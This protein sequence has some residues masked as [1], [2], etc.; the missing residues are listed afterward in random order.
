MAAF[1]VGLL[2][3]VA[4]TTA[5]LE[6][7]GF[8]DCE[9]GPLRNNSVC[10][11]SADPLSRAT[12]LIAAFTLE[13]KLNN[14]GSTAPGVP[15]LGLPAY[16]WWQEALHGV[17][18]SPGVNFS[19]SGEFRYAT[20][21]PQPIL[22]GAAF[23]DELIKDVATV[24]ST[25]A[26][27]F[28]NANRAG[29]D[30]WTPN[31]NPFKD[32]RWGR[33]QETPGEDPLHL[34]SYV[35]S[36]IE[37]LQGSPDDKYKRVVATCKHFVAYDI[38][39]W[40]GNFRYQFDAQVNQ[41]DLVEYYMPPF[42][43]CAGDSNVGAFMCSYNALNG[44]P[45]CA[46]PWLLQTVLREHW[47][48]TAEEQ[49]VTSDCDAIQ[50]VY[51]PHEYGKTREEA[52]ALSLKAGT[53]VNCGTYYQE[54][55][56]AAYDQGLIN[57]TD[58]NTA[59]IRQYSSLVRLGYFDGMA[60]PYRSLTWDD[61]STPQAQQLAYKAAVEGITLLKNDGT[62][63]FQ[64]QNSTKIALIGD[65]ANATDQMLGNYDGIPPYF[66]SPLYAA[67]QSGATVNFA[68]YPGGQGDP[69]TDNWL[70]IWNAANNSDVIVYAGGIDNSVEAEAQLDV[71]GQL[72][73]YGK[74]VIVLQMG[75]GQ[76]DSSPLVNNPNISALIWGGYPGQDGGVALF[77]IIQGKA[78][79]AGRLPTTQYPADYISQIPMTDMTLRPNATTGSPGRTYMWYTGKPIYEFGYG[80]HY[81]NFSASFSNN[82][83]SAS[84]YS[85]SSLLDGCTESYKDRCAFQTFAVDVKNTGAVTSDYVTLGFLAGT[86]GPAPYPRK[87][88]VAYQRLHNVTGGAMQTASLNLTLNSL[89]RVDDMGNKV[90]YPGDYALLIDTQP[91][92]TVNFTL[93]GEPA[94]LDEWPQPPA[95]RGQNKD[96]FVGGYGS[97]YEEQVPVE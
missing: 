40:N 46:D 54:H 72:A 94:V 8:P 49:W 47:N 64:I 16:T 42:E 31:I 44:V 95:A 17:A 48:W 77:D 9:N 30:F 59:L 39:N 34:S 26:R 68:G 14:T 97:T 36:L 32:S 86:H 92:A 22:M 28:S 19:D 75:G 65:W 87:R 82:S 89:A 24:I 52:A 85:I 5:Q 60:V 45:T 23:D 55:L 84:S 4:S 91:L 83:T 3:L 10:D 1:V 62:L 73:T 57:E 81:T 33:G 96:Y 20:S 70:H 53:D 15:R 76:I 18:Q 63:P 12:A 35:H 51:L 69:T 7:R 67:Q 88:L 6:G 11:T 56:P 74:P 21:F 2:A 37:G 25:E 61:V 50:N 78:A 29:L 80:L 13:E 66:H 79:P 93:T 27:A 90:L 38:E 71:I 43:S 58:L 41:Q